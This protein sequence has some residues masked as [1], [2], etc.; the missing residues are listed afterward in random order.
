MTVSHVAMLAGNSG[1]LLFI[2]VGIRGNL[3]ESA[4]FGVVGD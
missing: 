2:F 4:I 1:V 3:D